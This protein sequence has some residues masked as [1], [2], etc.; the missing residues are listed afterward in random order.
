MHKCHGRDRMS[1]HFLCK[2]STVLIYR[3]LSDWPSPNERACVRACVHA[4]RFCNVCVYVFV[5]VYCVR[6]RV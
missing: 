1:M 5:N 2:H 3:K 4:V 6:V